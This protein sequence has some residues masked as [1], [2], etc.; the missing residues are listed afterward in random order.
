MGFVGERAFGIQIKPI[1]A[2]ANFGNYSISERMKANF[3]DFE[4]KY[5]GRVFIIFSLDGEIGNKEV[6][7]EIEI[8]IKKLK[9]K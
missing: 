3:A 2:K 8:E 5:K 7:K 4:K 6:I 1:T 9:N